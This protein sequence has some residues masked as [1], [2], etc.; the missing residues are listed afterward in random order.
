[1]PF[2]RDQTITFDKI[3]QFDKQNKKKK[4]EEEEEEEEEDYTLNKANLNKAT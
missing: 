2:L 1:M 4:E 3:T